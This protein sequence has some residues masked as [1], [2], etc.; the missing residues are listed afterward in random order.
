M[1]A[2]IAK[3]DEAILEIQSYNRQNKTM[4]R[5]RLDAPILQ[6]GIPYYLDAHSFE[7]LRGTPK[8]CYNN[9]R[10]KDIPMK[11]PSWLHSSARQVPPRQL[12]VSIQH[13]QILNLTRGTQ[14]AGAVE[15]ADR[16]P[17]RTKGLLGRKGLAP[18]GGMWIVPC[19]SVHT[20]G[21]QF[22][23]DLVYL[24]RKHRVK[25]VTSSVPP[26][27]LSACLTAHSIVE[28]PA[29]TIRRTQTEK[30]DFLEFSP[31]PA[32]DFQNSSAVPA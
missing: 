12:S 21:M 2:A 25:K 7:G 26:W 29:G 32:P 10:S 31:V 6:H 24:D 3:Q 11:L 20:F 23:I 1:I 16:G 22:P 8:R 17:A 18:G 4:S 14:L 30:G 28:L 15:V 13:M 5:T 27:R 19:E 9:E